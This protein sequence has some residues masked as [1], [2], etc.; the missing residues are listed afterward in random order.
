MKTYLCMEIDENGQEH[1]S[2]RGQF[3]N[4]ADAEEHFGWEDVSDDFSVVLEK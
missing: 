1:E 2:D 3:A 4:L